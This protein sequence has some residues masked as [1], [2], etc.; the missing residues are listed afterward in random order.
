M[1][2]KMSERLE[3]A[4]DTVLEVLRRVQDDEE[5][6]IRAKTTLFNITFMLQEARRWEV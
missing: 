1:P 2:K 6:R 4:W 5:Q 3:E